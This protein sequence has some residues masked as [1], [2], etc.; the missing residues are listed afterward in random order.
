MDLVDRFGWYLR[1]IEGVQSTMALTDVAKT[2][3][4]GWN[5]GSLK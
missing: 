5:E 4:S 2:I 3:T 1:N